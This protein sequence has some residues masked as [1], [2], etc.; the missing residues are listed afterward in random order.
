VSDN[1]LIKLTHKHYVTSTL[2]IPQVGSIPVLV[3]CASLTWHQYPSLPRWLVASLNN[4]CLKSSG[5]L[6]GVIFWYM[7]KVSGSLV[8]PIFRVLGKKDLGQTSDPERLVIHQ[9][10]TP[11]NNP[12][13]FK[14]HYDHG[15]SLQL[16]TE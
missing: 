13:D 15:G 8:C 3:F 14:Q 6:P 4:V 11:G 9:K 10:M 5:L 1:T 16:H 7:T 2:W 12:E